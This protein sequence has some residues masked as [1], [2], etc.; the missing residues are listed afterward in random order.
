MAPAARN[1]EPPESQLAN[2][3]IKTC[4]VKSK[5]PIAQ[6]ARKHQVSRIGGISA[7]VMVQLRHRRDRVRLD[8]LEAMT[9]FK[10]PRYLVPRDMVHPNNAG[11]QKMAD[12]VVAV[13]RPILTKL[14]GQ[15][16]SQ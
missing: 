13:L 2:Q 12:G 4:L 5:E 8:L 6:L 1:T 11:E 14:S 15:K 3:K 7:D 16:D 10:D 9:F